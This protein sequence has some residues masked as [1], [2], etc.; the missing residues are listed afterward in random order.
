MLLYPP[1]VTEK[2]RLVWYD[3]RGVRGA[4][5]V[6]DDDIGEFALSSDGM[7][8]AYQKT[9]PQH[10]GTTLV[11]ADLARAT[12][13]VISEARGD[14]NHPVWL[15]GDH[16]IAFS[17]TREGMYDIFA[18]RPEGGAPARRIWTSEIDK[19]PLSVSP[20]GRD[21]IVKKFGSNFDLWLVP[22]ADGAPRPLL[23]AASTSEDDAE[24]SPDGY[25][26]VV[27]STSPASRE[28]YLRP[29]AGG[30]TTQ[31]TSTGVERPRWTR[32][33]DA[34]LYLTPDATLM[35]VRVTGKGASAKFDIARP[36]ASLR[37]GTIGLA[38]APDGRLLV[39]ERTD[40]LP[41]PSVYRAL[42]GWRERLEK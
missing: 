18:M 6:E 33:G 20:D 4:T 23:E 14:H 10:G 22:L 37:R 17:S 39:N 35:E 13:T 27:L 19:D 41:P 28:L 32:S 11:L 42:V 40:E 3:R 38:I 25:W 36:I 2:R 30:H 8:V 29:L 12:R 21:L 7:R 16:E 5:A 9:Q 1:L 24:I 15:P 34:I 31:L 26:L